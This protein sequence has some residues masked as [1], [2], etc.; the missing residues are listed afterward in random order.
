MATPN[1]HPWTS[2]MSSMCRSPNQ[3][4]CGGRPMQGIAARC[5]WARLLA[6]HARIGPFSGP[7]RL[8]EGTPPGPWACQCCGVTVDLT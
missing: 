4:P 5:G 2:L 3:E 7:E 8:W 1:G 6:P